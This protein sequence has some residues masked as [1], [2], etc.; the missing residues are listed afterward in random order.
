M[1]K[2]NKEDILLTIC[3]LIFFTGIC[4]AFLKCYGNNYQ[5]EQFISSQG[6]THPQ[7][8]GHD[9]VSCENSDMYKTRFKA[10]KNLGKEYKNY[11]GIICCSYWEECRIEELEEVK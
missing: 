6:F 1:F 7:I 3:V 9:S 2:I 8:I 5:A 4:L 10:K 11:K